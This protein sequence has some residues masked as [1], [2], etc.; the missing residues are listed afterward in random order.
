MKKSSFIEGTVIATLSIIIVKILGMLYVIPFYATVGIQ[1]SALYAY[2][3]NIYI[4][5]LDISTAGLPIAIS[6]II[7]EYNTLNMQEAKVRAY[8]IGKKIM[9]FIAVAIFLLLMIFAKNI[10]SVLLGDLSGGNTIEDVAFAIRCVSFAILVIP[11]LSVSKGYLQGHKIINVSSISQVIEQIIRIAVIL[12]GSYLV[13]NVFKGSLTLA[14]GI[15]VSGAFVGGLFAYLYVSKK[16]RDNK[17]EIGLATT[18]KEKDNVTNKEIIKKIISYAVPFIIINIVG[19]CYNFI[20]MTLILRFMNYLKLDTTDIE[21]VA[22][23]ITTWA[24]KINMIVTSFAM[25]LTVSLIP[26]IVTAFTLKKWDDVNDK[27]NQALQI[28][29]FVSIPCVIGIS[30]LSTGIWSIFYGYNYYGS[31]I[32]GLNIFTGLVLNLYMVTSSTLQGLNKFKL[33]YKT[34]ICG[35]ACNALLDIPIMY[36]FSKIGIP[37]FLGACVASIIGYTLSIYIALSS[38][39]KEHK[40]SYKKTFKT[41]KKLLI[42]TL[43]MIIVVFIFKKIIPINYDSKLSSLVYVCICSIMGAITFILISFKMK[44]VE[45]VM[46]KSM[47]NKIIK[48]LTFNKVRID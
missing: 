16:I 40:L 7:N 2:A 6:K 5:F 12:L 43:A 17:K 22:S 21:F 8:Y 45:E 28:I 25:G 44:L 29:L 46:G 31:I 48:K 11:F 38:L 19:S 13:L 24:P 15:A 20:D 30:M 23:A 26:N 34:T 4:I 1:G 41:L 9:G 42:P 27:L 32:L 35:F 47:T 14:V 10:A 36:L 39:K 18:F 3:Y 37:P 33:V